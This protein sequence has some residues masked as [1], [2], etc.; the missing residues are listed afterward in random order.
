MPKIKKEKGNLTLTGITSKA[1]LALLEAKHSG[2]VFIS[3][4][5]NGETWGARDLL[6]LDAWV[7]CRTYSPLRTIAYEIKV[8]RSDFERD[9]KWEKYLEL[10][11]EFYFVCPAGLIRN[12]DLP[13]RVGLVW[14]SQDALFTKKR[15]ER[16]DPNP[17]KLINLLIYALMARVQIVTNIERDKEPEISHLEQIRKWTEEASTK[18]ELAVFIRGHIQQVYSHIIGLDFSFQQ[19]ESNIKYFKD[20]LERLG[21]IWNS[22]DNSWNESQKVHE[23]IEA[24]KKAVDLS[25]IRQMRSLSKSLSGAADEL[26]P[27]IRNNEESEV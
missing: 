2:D 20:A 14:A 16:I 15:A 3:E 17:E 13:G 27:L 9:T 6:K 8:S 12:H 18:K 19:R 26:E 23:S 24:L 5:K 21:I 11:H 10:C 7:L 25:T 22:E 1:I 4:C